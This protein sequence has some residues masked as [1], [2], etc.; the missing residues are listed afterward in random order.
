MAAIRIGR[1]SHA[2]PGRD[3]EADALLVYLRPVDE[4]DRFVQLVGMLSVNAAILPEVDPAVTI[5]LV[6]LGPQDL[7]QAYRSGFAGTHYTVEVP[8][9]TDAIGG[10]R[11]AVV[12][13][14]YVDGR[15]GVRYTDQ[16]AV[17]LQPL[18]ARAEEAR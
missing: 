8:V 14:T 1:L 15:S 5:G 9:R 3:D 7:R 11:E 13:V 6:Q 18:R 17:D 16:R 12:Q 10:H 2:R 4:L